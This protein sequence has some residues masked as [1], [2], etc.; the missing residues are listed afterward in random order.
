MACVPSG[1]APGLSAMLGKA[2]VHLELGLVCLC[3]SYMELLLPNVF[4][5]LLH[6]TFLLMKDGE[7]LC[8]PLS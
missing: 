5:Q 8:L 6:V 4:L 7:N 2:A 1:G 3:T